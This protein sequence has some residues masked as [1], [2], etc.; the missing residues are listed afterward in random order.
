[1]SRGVVPVKCVVRVYRERIDRTDR[2]D[3]KDQKL[4]LI[5][6]LFSLVQE[7]MPRVR[8]DDLPGHPHTLG[9]DKP[10]MHARYFARAE[11]HATQLLSKPK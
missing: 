9:G 1:M 5:G 4:N 3:E 11:A 6:L 2:T 7:D 8:M 10:R